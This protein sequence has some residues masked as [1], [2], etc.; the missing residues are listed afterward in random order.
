ME[1]LSLLQPRHIYAPES[2]QGHIYS[3]TA[4][5]L[6]GERAEKAGGTIGQI[7]DENLRPF[8]AK[9]NVVG[10][11]L[12][13]PPY[14][15]VTR[16]IIERVQRTNKD[17]RFLLGGQIVDSLSEQEFRN[18]FGPNALN[19]NNDMTVQEVL[20]LKNPLPSP[21]E[22]SLVDIYERIPDE[23]MKEYLSREG[24]LFVSQ[25]CKYNCKPCIAKKKMPERYREIQTLETD[26]QYLVKRAKR[27]G[28]DNLS[29]Y[30]SNLDVFQTPRKLMQFTEVLKGIQEDNPGFTIETRGLATL[31][32]FCEC[33][34]NH[35]EVIEALAN[36]GFHTVAFGVDGWGKEDWKEMRKGHNSEEKC[37]KAISVAAEEY[38]LT[39][40][41]LM[42]FGHRSSTR[43]SLKET[44]RIVEHLHEKYGAIPRPHIVK[45]LL[46]GLEEW[47]DPKNEKYKRRL[48]E[49]PWD[50]QA[51]DF[52]CLP[53]HYSHPHD[54][55]TDDL[56][57][58][59]ES[60][61]IDMVAISNKSTDLIYPVTSF[62]D[63]ETNQ[64][65]REKNI[66]QY[67]R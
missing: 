4:L 64:R 43:E 55:N 15:P 14:I 46:P 12:L 23:D 56:S 57:N 32:D 40:E 62:Q 7:H 29:F 25:G 53:S 22:T 5:W 61:S 45:N 26:L 48:A 41:I 9:T 11:S 52:C 36:A 24:S 27:L 63:E 35:P 67:D 33:H 28:I 6:A 58:S 10:I 37:F 60:A 19:G 30:L 17:A 3:N 16:D 44:V 31:G 50:Y 65:N 49:N 21:Y 2:G 59:I 18:L 42:V 51:L 54:E 39:P 47:N 8:E 1:K 13:G 34:D 66:G 38:G 20:G